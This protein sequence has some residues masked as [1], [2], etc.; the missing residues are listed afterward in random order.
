MQGNSGGGGVCAHPTPFLFLMADKIII[1][2]LAFIMCHKQ[3]DT[4]K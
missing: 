1:H 2:G 3:L 4:F